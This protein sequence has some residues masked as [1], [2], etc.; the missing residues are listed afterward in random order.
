VK[1]TLDRIARATGGERRG[2]G[3]TIVEGFSNDSRVIEPGECF[4]ALAGEADA[5][6]DGHDFVG[7]AFARG[8]AAALVAR[9]PGGVEGSFVVVDD[10][11]DALGALARA[12]RSEELAAARVVGITGSTGKTSTK[13][14]LAAALGPATRVAA[15]R[16]SFNNEIGLPITLLGAAADREFVICEMGA[17]FAGNIAALCA[18][19]DPDVGVVTNVGAAHAEHLGGVEGIESVKGELL[20]ALPV[21]G[22][23][24]LNADDPA[25][26][27]LR[28][29]VRGRVLTVGSGGAV[30]VRIA[31][32]ETG[33]DL[34]AD[35]ELTTPW[36]TVRA[37]LGL[38]GA[39]QAANAALAAAVALD[40]G[41][42]PDV[43]AAGLESASGSLW[44]M[45]LTSTAAG[46]VVL[47]DAYNANPHS[48]AAAL[49]ALRYLPVPGRRHAVLGEMRELGPTAVAAHAE[50]GRRCAEHRIDVVIAVGTGRAMD[51][52]DAA[53][54]AA[55]VVVRRVDDVT[56]ARAALDLERG[57]AVLVKASRAVGLEAL[58]LDLVAEFETEVSEPRTGEGARA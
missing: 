3:T 24:V 52:L 37:R 40:A 47:N 29:R 6:R 49:S 7:D 8:A 57:D 28:A 46:V 45:E 1:L 36:G 4:V 18:I 51:S 33:P 38:R 50:I 32:I 44:R 27:R 16:A 11:L 48:V 14:F 23:A 42:T 25:T 21:G 34:R 55:G 12:T 15:N 53:A 56:A 17:R 41:V 10:V 19:A 5:K 22:L 30:D 54:R 13:D 43:V 39:H 2:A 58:A 35:V 31:R 26:A 9:I 20:D